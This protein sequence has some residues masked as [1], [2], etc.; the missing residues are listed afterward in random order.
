MLFADGILAKIIK[1][2][3]NVYKIIITGK[4]E[5]SYC[6]KRDELFSHGETIREAKAGLLFKISNRDTSKFKNWRLSTKISYRDAIESYRI[7][8]G[9]CEYGTKMFAA[10]ITA[11]KEYT[12]SEVIKIT[13]EQYGNETY[14]SFF[15]N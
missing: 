2:K 9:A 4:T 1:H 10:T 7:I 14:K 12:V 8:T 3:G 6:V 11:K 15:T 13:E 5:I